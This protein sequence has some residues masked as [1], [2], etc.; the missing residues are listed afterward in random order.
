MAQLSRPYQIGLVAVAV[1]AAAWVLLI[2]GHRSSSE[3]TSAPSTAR[4]TNT[5][6]HAAAPAKHAE[7]TAG[8][9][10]GHGSASSLGS[11]GH[12]VEKAR[13]AV[14]TSKQNERQLG[15]RSRQ[16]SSETATTTTTVA[17]A[18]APAV[19]SSA[20]A[21]S[22]ATTHAKSKPVAPSA[23]VRGA[24]ARQRTVEAQIAHGKV[25]VILFWD[26]SGS[27]DRLVHK[28]LRSLRGDR[29]LKIAIDEA[30]PSQVASFGTVTRGVQ[31]FG[32]PTLLFVNGKDQALVRTGFQDAYS[33]AQAVREARHPARA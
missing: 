15:E 20:P 13:G 25:A 9:A 6:T 17:P 28:A 27:D 29:T 18:P 22:A 8:S 16:A 31:V 4:V 33:I 2:H 24:T 5:T 7:G 3:S 21:P 14:G 11:L 26:P 32:T 12:A 10:T 1:L 23:A 30:L 19:K